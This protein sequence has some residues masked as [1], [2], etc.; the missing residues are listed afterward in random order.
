MEGVSHAAPNCVYLT[1]QYNCAKHSLHI[2]LYLTTAFISQS[3]AYATYI[4]KSQAM[5]YFQSIHHVCIVCAFVSKCN[6]CKRVP[7]PEIHL[8]IYGTPKIRPQNK[9]QV[10]R[11]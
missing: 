3:Q 10:L 4:P 2:P 6:I 11:T 5:E 7:T 1:F 9:F 8:Q